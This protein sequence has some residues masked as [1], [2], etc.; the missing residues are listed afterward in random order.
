M[1]HTLKPLA[2]IILALGLAGVIVALHSRSHP[3]LNGIGSP[4][5]APRPAPD[6]AIV[7]ADP[8]VQKIAAADTDFGFRLLA[9]LAPAKPRE[10]VFFS[11]FSI[12]QALDLT[13]NGAGGQTQQGIASTLG[14]KGLPLDKVNQANGLLLPSLENP[15]PQVQLS[16]ANALWIQQGKSFNP[17]FQARCRQFYDADTTALNFGS[18]NAA[19]TIN[20]WVSQNTQGKISQIVSPSDLANANA[21]L[22]NAVYF[23]G[24]WATPFD[25]ASTR[26]GLFTHADGSQKTMPLMSHEGRYSYLQ[27][28]TFQA[29]RLPYGKGRLAM[30]IFLPKSHS[31]LEAFLKT[32]TAAQCE[33][34][35]PQMHTTE[36]D[37]RL[38]RFHADYSETLNDS[39]S[40]MGMAP[41]FDP[42]AD[43]SPMGLRNSYISEVVHKATLDVDE[44]GTIATAVTAGMMPASIPTPAPPPIQMRVDHPFFCAI[45]DDATGTILFLGAIR[46]P[47]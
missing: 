3:A 24:K 22:T 42:T 23:H 13:L 47:Q 10:N 8:F 16:V 19:P 41:A 28:D 39:L 37:L 12:S 32:T 44:E 27:T 36:L 29:V 20:G 17:K 15:D 33:K 14:L 5:F 1:K 30:Y 31:G 7:Q 35:L 21:V 6:L 40:H 43:F 2:G 34:W 45:R 11:P 25:K 26:N 46:D 9:L 38:P 18:A 4:V